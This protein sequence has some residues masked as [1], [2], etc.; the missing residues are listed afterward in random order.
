MNVSLTEELEL[1]IR[2]KV[3]SGLYTSSSEVVRAALRLLKR[4]DDA[5]QQKLEVLRADIREG[6]ESGE[7]IDADAVFDGLKQELV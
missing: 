3:E 7:P 6:L 1:F 4:Q 5:E 2:A